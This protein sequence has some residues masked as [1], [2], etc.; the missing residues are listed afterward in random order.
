MQALSPWLLY[1]LQSDL[2]RDVSQPPVRS[3][4]AADPGA[5]RGMVQVIGKQ[6]KRIDMDTPSSHT[7]D[8]DAAPCRRGGDSLKWNRYNQTAHDVIGAWVADMDFLTPGPVLEAV[9]KRLDGCPLGYCDPP[10][11]LLPLFLA[12][13]QRLYGWQID[14][15]WVVMLSGVVPGLYGAARAVGTPGDSLITQSPNY[16]HFFGAAEFSDRRLLTL[17]NH[18]SNGHW[19]MDFDQLQHHA[20]SGAR[21]FLL[22]N[23]HNPVG[24]VLST[25]EL[26]QVARVCDQ[27]DIVICSDEIHADIILDQDKQHVPI[28]TLSREVADRT[29]TLVS[30]SKTF[31]M[32][33]VGGF[34][35]AIIPNAKLRRDFQR[36]LHGFSV[37]PGA[38]AYAAALAAYRDCDDWLAQLLHYLRGNRDQLE[39]EVA[40][41]EGISMTHVEATFLAWINVAGLGIENPQA[42]FLAHGVAFSDGGPLGDPQYLRLNFACTRRT[43]DEI[44]KRMKRAIAAL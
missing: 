28:A 16:H 42:Q 35:L 40:G 10:T 38:L 5:A 29:I 22:C 3:S 30:P 25:A 32:P 43:L 9:R 15:D 11:E 37:Q 18:V 34:A 27:H 17:D 26:E 12:R 20:A 6:S 21:C 4:L 23:P 36:C 14:P 31:N 2:T 44:L 39:E 8:F 13:M 41:I 1:P 24:R 33:G 19:E 7:V